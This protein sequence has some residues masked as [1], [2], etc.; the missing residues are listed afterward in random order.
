MSPTGV[1]KRD[2][3]EGKE[4]EPFLSVEVIPALQDSPLTIYDWNPA[5][6]YRWCNRE[7]M[8]NGR[9]GIWHAVPR[10][11][12]DFKGLRVAVDH[13]PETNFFRYKDL[14]LCCA[15]KETVDAHRARL[16]DK[17]ARRDA[18]LK[19][20]EQQVIEA[21]KQNLSDSIRILDKVNDGADK[22]VEV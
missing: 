2:P 3:K 19:Q 18:H 15:R 21:T 16:R 12:G 4:V 10:D 14:I 5:Y 6:T 9:K 7:L 17:V 11:H 20:E 22:I 1:Y 8:A 13:E